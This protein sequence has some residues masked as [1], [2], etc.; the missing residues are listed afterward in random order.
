[1]KHAV[2][3]QQLPT[4]SI[5]CRLLTIVRYVI[6][7]A[8]VSFAIF[9]VV[10]AIATNATSF[11]GVPQ[12]V[13][14]L[15]LIVCL[16]CLGIVE[17]LQIALVELMKQHTETYRVSHPRAYAT[18]VLCF[19]GENLERFL[20]GRQLCVIFLVFFIA[21]L[22]TSSILWFMRENSFES[23]VM[24]AGLLGALIVAVLAQ[25]APQVV[26]TKYPVHFLNLRGMNGAL[27]I[28]L[29]L[30]STGIAHATW[31]VAY[32]WIRLCGWNAA[33]AK[34]DIAHVSTAQQSDATMGAPVEGRLSRTLEKERRRFAL[35]RSRNSDPDLFATLPSAG[36][37]AYSSPVEL[38]QWFS[39]RGYEVPDFLTDVSDPRHVPPHIVAM[40]LLLEHV[41]SAPKTPST[42]IALSSET[43]TASVLASIRPPTPTADPAD[44]D[45]VI[46]VLDKV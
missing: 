33:N 14:A 15:L 22:T 40:E 23:F 19:R 42:R 8:L 36:A 9:V 6:S 29:A 25:L 44:A 31:L 4:E 24:E 41:E 43:S 13:Q 39:S 35:R 30:E 17:G 28:C 32:G 1:M 27:R 18:G 21:R 46:E 11:F 38:A 7:C 20:I 37:S 10:A 26:A 45:P 3:E 12:W 2:D 34:P 16:V 5:G